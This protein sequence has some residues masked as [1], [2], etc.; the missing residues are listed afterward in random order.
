MPYEGVP[1]LV[2]DRGSDTLSARLRERIRRAG[3]ISFHDWMQAALYDELEGY[4]RREGLNPWGR[5]GDY[6]TSPERSP[7]FAATFARFF[8]A[9]HKELGA[10]SNW[11]IW[12][13]GAGAGHF[14]QGL[15]ETLASTDPHLY[16]CTRYVFDETSR[17]ARALAAARLSSFKARVE[18]INLTEGAPPLEAGVIFANELLDAFPIHRLTMQEGRLLELF[19][20]TDEAGNFVWTERE[21]STPR[22]AEYLARLNVELAEGQAA[23][24]NLHAVD[25]IRRAASLLRRGYLVLV[26][27][28]AEADELFDPS[29]RPQGTL[30]AFRQHRFI[31]DLLKAP[32]E[33]DITTTID[34]T[35]II[36]T[37]RE[38]GL[39]I[40]SFERQDK[41][42]LRAGLLEE[43]SRLTAGGASEAAAL[44][45]S[46]SARELVL[47][48]GMSES[49]QVL[50]AG[51]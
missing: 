19:V 24:I 41:F 12:E 51:R 22:L 29:L 26:D 28:G 16:A 34:W 49:F 48:V 7:L 36:R 14:A 11:T 17:R 50:V 43:L 30:R 10:P 5:G 37:C 27:Y 2:E 4:Y 35:T 42:L 15:M 8:A 25:W 47:P 39:E 38:E 46:A 32:G 3:A 23:E 13:A 40:I 45:L 6:R 33:Q 21:P 44:S 20:E 9:L 31:E 18:Y 1:I